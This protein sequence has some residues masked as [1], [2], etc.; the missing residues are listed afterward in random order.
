MATCVLIIYLLLAAWIVLAFSHWLL[1]LAKDLLARFRNDK[2]KES[3]TLD[4]TLIIDNP[5]LKKPLQQFIEIVVSAA[6][7]LFFLYL[8]HLII[9]TATW[10][11]GFHPIDN[12]EFSDV[13]LQGTLDTMNFAFYVAVTFIILMVVWSKWNYWR[14]GRLERR[15][16]RPPVLEGELANMFHLSTSIITQMQKTKLMALIPLPL[17]FKLQEVALK[18]SNRDRAPEVGNRLWPSL[19]NAVV[20]SAK[21]GD[22]SDEKE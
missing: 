2:Q 20:T 19:R 1:T 4:N 11:L 15:Q 6:I 13:A 9:T 5:D 7:W 21:M 14:F 16:F 3:Q 18:T 22:S 12:I 8:F 10:I 17:G